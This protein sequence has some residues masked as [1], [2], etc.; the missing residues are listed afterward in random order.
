MVI[1]RIPATCPSAEVFAVLIVAVAVGVGPRNKAENAAIVIKAFCVLARYHI[2]VVGRAVS[3][4]IPLGNFFPFSCA[5]V[6]LRV[7]LEIVATV[8][9]AEVAAGAF[10]HHLV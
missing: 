1:L 10:P 9:I 4:I 2:G 5:S 8:L 7:I 3:G 6:F